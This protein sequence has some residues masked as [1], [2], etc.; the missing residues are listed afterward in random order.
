MAAEDIAARGVAVKGRDLLQIID[1]VAR[2]S[3]FIQE[4]VNFCCR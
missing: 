3:L 2:D 4:H 1:L